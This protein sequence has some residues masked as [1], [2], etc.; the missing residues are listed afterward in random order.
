[1][2]FYQIKNTEKSFL[3]PLRRICKGLT[4][5]LMKNN[6]YCPSL[7]G[8]GLILMFEAFI[9][10][11]INSEDEREKYE[12]QICPAL[13]SIELLRREVPSWENSTHFSEVKLGIGFPH[14]N[15]TV[16][17]DG[18]VVVSGHITE[19]A[20]KDL[21]AM[22]LELSIDNMDKIYNVS[23]VE[24]VEL[25]LYLFCENY[26]RKHMV[27]SFGQHGENPVEIKGIYSYLLRFTHGELQ[28]KLGK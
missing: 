14:G 25:E 21:H 11:G 10:C 6:F 24:E 8:L 22:V 3:T 2:K 13:D 17:K 27:K 19:T 16:I 18:T 23:A 20:K 9:G 7:S 12:C 15:Y 4:H 1:M 26:Q 28:K 5:G